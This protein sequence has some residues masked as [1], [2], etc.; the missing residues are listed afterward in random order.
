MDDGGGESLGR[1]NDAHV[2]SV[3]TGRYL[4]WSGEERASC[5]F[6]G[7]AAWGFALRNDAGVSGGAANHGSETSEGEYCGLC[8]TRVLLIF[9]ARMGEERQKAIRQNTIR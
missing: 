2:A 6:Y 1:A 8:I 4:S 3:K 7:A 9:Y 5:L